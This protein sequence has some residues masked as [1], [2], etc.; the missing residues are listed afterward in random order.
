MMMYTFLMVLQRFCGEAP[1]RWIAVMKGCVKVGSCDEACLMV[2]GCYEA[3]YGGCID[4]VKL[5]WTV[6]K[7]RNDEAF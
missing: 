3:C 5:V 4:V 7:A 2:D 6:V 1:W